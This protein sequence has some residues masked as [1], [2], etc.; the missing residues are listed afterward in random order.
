VPAARRGPGREPSGTSL[1]SPSQRVGL[2][3]VGERTLAVDLD[4][5][6][7]AAVRGLELGVAVDLDPLEAVAAADLLDDL[8]RA[9]AEV[10]AGSRVDDDR[11]YG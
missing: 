6:E 8:E 5:G 10:A 7:S 4:H 9:L 2:H 1:E 11:R 3:E